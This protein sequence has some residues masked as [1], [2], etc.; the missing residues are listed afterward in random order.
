MQIMLNKEIM[1]LVILHI[2]LN[3]KNIIYGR[4]V[5]HLGHFSELIFFLTLKSSRLRKSVHLYMCKMAE[6]C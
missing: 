1:Y 4:I 2:E 3:P 5:E 6:I